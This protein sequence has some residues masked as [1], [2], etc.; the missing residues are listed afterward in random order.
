MKLYIILILH[1]LISTLTAGDLDR[2]AD[3][4][5]GNMFIPQGFVLGTMNSAGFSRLVNKQVSNAGNLNPASLSQFE[6]GSLGFSYQFETKLDPAYYL[7]ITHSRNVTAKP[8]S[9]SFVANLENVSYA[10]SFYQRFN[11]MVN[12]G[13]I[14]VATLDQ[15]EGIG[16]TF[17]VNMKEFI[18]TYALILS[19][20]FDHNAFTMGAKL[21]VSFLN[22]QE[23]IYHSKASADMNAFSAALGFT[24]KADDVF[25]F[26]AYYERAPKFEGKLNYNGLQQID[27]DAQVPGNH[28]VIAHLPDAPFKTNLPDLLNV[29]ASAKLNETFNAVTDLSYIFW[30]QLSDNFNNNLDISSSLI[31]ALDSDLMLSMGFLLTYRD[32]TNDISGANSKLNALFLLG[33]VRKRFGMVVFDSALA[34]SHFNSGKWRE[35]LIAK[36]GIDIY[37]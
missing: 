34:S 31:A 29:A 16:E 14:E 6:N 32:N 37:L 25:T 18:D 20:P 22:M 30:K 7:D 19:Y 15:P 26:A 27:L 13:E 2:V 17:S 28:R 24:Y 3:N 21:E 9:I 8:Q 36:L 1:L 35:Q 33:G 23:Q 5:P 10:F 11:S 4:S 12:L